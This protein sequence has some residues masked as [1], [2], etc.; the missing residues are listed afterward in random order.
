MSAQN[1]RRTVEI[2]STATAVFQA[3][4]VGVGHW[5]TEPDRPMQKLGDQAK[6]AFPPSSSFWTFALTEL[7]EPSRVEWTCTG[8]H[9]VHEGLP[10]SIEKEWLHTKVLWTMKEVNGGVIVTLEHY[11]HC[12]LNNQILRVGRDFQAFCTLNCNTSTA[13]TAGRHQRS[14]LLAKA[15]RHGLR[16]DRR[17]LSTGRT[18]WQLKVQY[19][20]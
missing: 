9:H 2:K 18:V 8:A 11:C 12:T 15:R 1:Y 3:V 19:C 4:T 5:W 14:V 13:N 20:N 7:I 17:K 10:K 6:F 16:R